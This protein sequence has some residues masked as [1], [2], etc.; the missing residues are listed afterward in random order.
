M[1]RS[2]LRMIITWTMMWWDGYYVPRTD[3]EHEGLVDQ[4]IDE[5]DLEL[6]GLKND[7]G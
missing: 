7:G 4:A 6:E 5:L 3:E 1:T 2:E